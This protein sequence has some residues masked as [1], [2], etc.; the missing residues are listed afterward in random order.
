M[1]RVAFWGA[2]CAAAFA[3]GIFFWH[4]HTKQ[5]VQTDS[6]A[7]FALG[8]EDAAFQKIL[9]GAQA[10]AEERGAEIKSYAWK[11]GGND[12][13]KK[14]QQEH[15]D[16]MIWFWDKDDRID[17]ENIKEKCAQIG[18]PVILIGP[19][20]AE[21]EICMDEK[22]AGSLM[23]QEA[24][25]QGAQSVVFLMDRRDTAAAWQ[26]DGAKSALPGDIPYVEADENG[27]WLP[28]EN[29]EQKREDATFVLAFGKAATEAAIEMKEKGRL[30]RN[31]PVIGTGCPMDVESLENGT[32]SALLYPSYFAM[33]YRAVEKLHDGATLGG[34]PENEQI[35]YRV[36]TLENLY[37]AE[38][39]SYVFPLLD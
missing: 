38:N 17:P 22:G 29:R 3:V 11:N 32:V 18:L 30:A 8:E 4:N 34:G 35:P 33:G 7:L 16:G 24:L 37:D 31:V 19:G 1:R 10:A 2:L 36:I 12:W 25:A 21:A 14:I 5:A 6:Y 23:V 26:L 27:R 9:Q 28:Q 13:M 20:T 15:T 39:V